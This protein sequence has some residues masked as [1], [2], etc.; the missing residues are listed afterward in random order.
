MNNQ[1]IPKVSQTTTDLSLLG[2]RDAFHVPGVLVTS[3]GYVSASDPVL[4]TDSSC[5]EVIV[6]T[7][8][9]KDAVVDPF[10]S[11]ILDPGTLFW[12]FITPERVSNL[13]HHFE[14]SPIVGA[15]ETIFTGE[16]SEDWRNRECYEDEDYECKDCYE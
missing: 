6:A 11:G 13:T 16:D 4:F 7:F 10:V 9:R 3:S 12:V 15:S 2:R 14:I 5:K 1:V 8:S